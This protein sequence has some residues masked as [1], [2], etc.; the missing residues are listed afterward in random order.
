MLFLGCIDTARILKISNTNGLHC[1]DQLFGS[2]QF[3]REMY[4]KQMTSEANEQ[5]VDEYD[6]FTSALTNGSGIWMTASYL[7]HSCLGSFITFVLLVVCFNFNLYLFA[8]T[9]EL[10]FGHTRDTPK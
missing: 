5:D 10:K 1:I 7:N 8:T 9:I 2:M 4:F 3:E 6:Q